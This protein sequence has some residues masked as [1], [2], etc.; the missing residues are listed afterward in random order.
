MKCRVC[1]IV[2]FA[3]CT[4]AALVADGTRAGDLPKKPAGRLAALPEPAERDVDFVKDVRPI[5]QRSC[6]SC[7]GAEAQEGGLRLH[8]RTDALA[9]GDSGPA[10]VNGKSAESR[11]IQFVSGLNE[12]NTIMPPDDGKPLAV[13]EIAILRKWIDQGSPWPDSVAGE[14]LTSDHWAFQK[15]QRPQLPAVNQAD[16]VQ[17][18]IDRFV[19]AKLESLNLAPSPAADKATLLRRVTLDLT[20]LLPTPDEVK[21]FLADESPQ[22]FERVVDRL[23]DS[24]QYGER[25]ARHWLD[26]ARYADSDGFEKDRIRPHA[27]RYRHWVINAFNRDLPFDQ[28]TLEQLAGDLLPD[29]TLEQLVATGF[30]R[31]TLTNTEGGADKEEDRVK[32]TVDRTNTTGTT[33]LGLTIGC[34]QC[35]S[36]KYDPIS[37]RDYYQLYSFFDSLQEKDLPAP[38]SGDDSEYQEQK[39]K[40]D[41]EHAEL[42]QQ[43]ARFE[44][45]QLPSRLAAWESKLDLSAAPA[46]QPLT[47]SKVTSSG[48][49]KLTVQKDA[50]VLASGPNPASDVYTIEA[51]VNLTRITALRIEALS[52]PSLPAKGPGRVKHGNFV[53]SEVALKAGPGGNANFLEPEPVALAA[54]KADFEQAGT[55]DK[56][57]WPA[58]A[59]VDNDPATGW[60]ISPQFGKDHTAVLELEKDLTAEGP[61]RLIVTLSQQYGMQHTLGKFR[62]SVTGAP[63]PV[64][65]ELLPPQVLAVLKTP[66]ATRTAEQQKVLLD[67]YRTLDAEAT[68]WTARLAAQAEPQRKDKSMAQT[69]V[70]LPSPR[71]T[72][73][74][75]RGDFLRPGAEVKPAVLEVLPDLPELDRPANRLDLARWLV[76]PENPLT[77]RVTVNRFWQRLFGQGLV[78]TSHDFGTQGREPTHPQLLDHLASEFMGGGWSMKQLIRQIV[79]SA[80]YQQSAQVRPELLVDDP[81]NELLARQSR[82]RVEAE[83]VRDVALHAAGLLHQQIG[84]PS[85]RPPQPDGIA[86]LGYANSVKWQ[87]S[88][89]TDRYRRGLYTFFQRTVPYPMLLDFDAPDSNVTCSRRE[90]SNTPISALTLQNDPVFV[91]C[92]QGFARRIG[93][94]LTAQRAASSANVDDAVRRAFLI[95]LGREPDQAELSAVA[96]LYD[97]GLKFGIANPKAAAEMIGSQAKPEGISDA[98][99]AGWTLVG[100]TLMNTDEFITRD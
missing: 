6:F 10:W 92:A 95:C 57:G 12:E 30:H 89:G 22:A 59:T 31:N 67:H 42:Q 38:L 75:T 83:I 97:E 2:S 23:L 11:L 48:G 25:W 63:R 5:L 46:W 1:K 71:T 60:A 36:H 47:P 43:L 56:A 9:G 39:K 19:L 17:N 100:R 77:A 15:V 90:S 87:T 29:P 13:A 55:K 99:L 78:V 61:T 33:W 68:A 41:Q 14:V 62:I 50:S 7:H 66:A 72:H 82:R 4:L 84:G 40:Y 3:L 18:A 37:H 94:Y 98:Q 88:T 8:R 20:G 80:T 74:L 58:S 93:E 91:E 45:E 96:G 49:A 21:N 32:Q 44:K 85:V 53:L 51:E 64:P 52:D 26:L 65:L 81:Y 24:P 28:F 54:A 86:S 76:S 79:T 35:H 69:L 34:A 27:W 73:I 70:E 16:W